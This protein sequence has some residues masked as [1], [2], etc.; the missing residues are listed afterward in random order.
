MKE[1]ELKNFVAKNENDILLELMLNTVIEITPI[2]EIT[3]NK[4][5][6]IDNLDLYNNVK[7]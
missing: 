1:M 6:E 2:E 5:K 4:A 7:H 3:C